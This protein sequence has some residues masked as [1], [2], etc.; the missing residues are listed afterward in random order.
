MINNTKITLRNLLFA[1]LATG[2]FFTGCDKHDHTSEENITKIEVH[3][4]GPG[5]DQKF[6]WED[7]D[8]DGGNPPT[9]QT[10][11]LNPNVVYSANLHLYD[12]DKEITSEIVQESNEHLFTFL[13]T[14]ADL[15]IGALSTDNNGNPFG[16]ESRWTT[17]NA[18]T[19]TVNI[20]LIHEPSNKNN[21][22]NPGG[23]T[24]FDV[25]FPVQIQ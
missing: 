13:V 19:G 25:V 24:D 14:G 23:D 18:S 11:V 3:I 4:T 15:S 2:L 12:G 7:A 22:A 8:G 6:V 17:G 1:L 5:F 20:K 21:P 9:I 10:I 16:I